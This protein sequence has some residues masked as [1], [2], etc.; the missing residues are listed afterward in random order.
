[1][2]RIGI[3]DDD[4]KFSKTLGQWVSKICFSRTEYEIQYFQ[5]GRNVINFIEEGGCSLDLLILDINMKYVNGM[6][7]AEYIRNEKLDMDI[8]FLTVSE[9]YVYRGYKYKA[10]AYLLKTVTYQEIYDELMRYLDE[11]EELSDMLNVSVRGNNIKIPL[12][13]VMYFSSERRVIT[14][15][16]KSEKVSFYEKME[17]VY[18]I[19][20]TEGFIRCHQSFIVNIKYIRQ[21]GAS[22]I[23]LENNVQIPVSRSYSDDVRRRLM[24]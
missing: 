11:R 1:M 17:N 5:D 16:L 4:I 21:S 15:F 2:I 3:C 22:K 23:V 19:V 9:K 13:D 18:E 20:Q 12:K 10:F 8:I 14:A 6:E 24:M 7:V